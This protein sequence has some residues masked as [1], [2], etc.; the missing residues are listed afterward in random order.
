ML[1]AKS[2]SLFKFL[3]SFSFVRKQKLYLFCVFQIYKCEKTKKV[4]I[5]P[6]EIRLFS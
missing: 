3:F 4:K 5:Q 1:N 6:I 2:K